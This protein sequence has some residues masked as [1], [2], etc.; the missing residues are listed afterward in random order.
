MIHREEFAE[1]RAA[2][3][4]TERRQKPN[5]ALRRS[6]KTMCRRLLSY[7]VV[8]Y[9]HVYICNTRAPALVLKRRLNT[10]I[11][12]SAS[13]KVL[14]MQSL[15][16][17]VYTFLYWFYI[18]VDMLCGAKIKIHFNTNCPCGW[19]NI[20]RLVPLM[21]NTRIHGAYIEKQATTTSTVETYLAKVFPI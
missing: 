13:R 17:I 14:N 20:H 2:L 5:R 11:V 18:C 6:D 12:W 4:R 10:T 21:E 15:K 3:K 8:I 19:A 1:T 9:K 16:Y 7:A